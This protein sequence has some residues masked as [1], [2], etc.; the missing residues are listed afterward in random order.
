MVPLQTPLRYIIQRGLLAYY[1]TALHFSALIIV[2]ICTIALAIGLQRQAINKKEYL[3]QPCAK[4]KKHKERRVIKT[5]FLLAVTYLACSTPTAA[6]MLVPH[7]EP[8][9]DTTRGFARIS[10]V[11][12]LLSGLMNQINSNANLFIFIYTGSKFRET[13]LRLFGKKSP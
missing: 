9:F 2:W 3:Q 4:E 1:G 8:Q 13:F 7:F 5:V 12:H 10:R 11:C 6:T